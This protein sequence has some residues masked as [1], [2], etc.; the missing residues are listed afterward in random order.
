MKYL[1]PLYL[2]LATRDDTRATA[3]EWFE[4]N[5]AGYHNIARQ[6]VD[7]LLKQNKA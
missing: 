4:A 5:K 6:V 2:A 3:R 7:N 1:K